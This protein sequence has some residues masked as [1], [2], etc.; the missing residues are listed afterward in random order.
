[1]MEVPSREGGAREILRY[2]TRPTLCRG[3]YG[4]VLVCCEAGALER[5]KHDTP[6]DEK[7]FLPPKLPPLFRWERKEHEAVGED[8]RGPAVTPP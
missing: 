8:S 5:A 6:Q 2:H 4:I 7:A 3:E 1:M